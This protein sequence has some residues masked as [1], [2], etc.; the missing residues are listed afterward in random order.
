MS[1]FWTRAFFLGSLG[2]GAL[3][4]YSPAQ[5][6]EWQVLNNPKTYI[7]SQE[8]LGGSLGFLCDAE[9]TAMVFYTFPAGAGSSLEEGEIVTATLILPDQ[10][11]YAI[12][13]PV[14]A[15]RFLGGWDVQGDEQDALLIATAVS[16]GSSSSKIVAY[17]VGEPGKGPGT[18]EL[19]HWEQRLGLEERSLLGYT[20]FTA[21][22]GTAALKPFFQRCG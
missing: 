2:I 3:V 17:A 8:L 12:R 15:N 4:A 14:A 11:P 13:R 18:M 10:T 16:A 1:I 20:E 6:Q 5:A 9:K 7:A 21:R 19:D 22:G